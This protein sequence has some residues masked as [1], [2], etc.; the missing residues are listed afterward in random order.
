MC[1]QTVDLQTF[2]ADLDA[3]SSVAQSV[4]YQSL[5]SL[6]LLLH[7]LTAVWHVLTRIY[8]A[9]SRKMRCC[10]S[11]DFAEPESFT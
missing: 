1:M 8:H 3:N 6:L 4:L 10:N 2:T 11:E 5:K 7:E 9:T